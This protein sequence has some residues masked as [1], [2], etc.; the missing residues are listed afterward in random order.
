MPFSIRTTTFDD[1]PALT[2]LIAES[3]RG[4]CKSDYTEAQIEAALQ[5]A[6]GVDSELIRDQT[7]F[8]VEQNNQIIACGGWSRRK[9]LFGGDQ[10]PDRQSELLNPAKEPARIRAFFVHPKAARNG[11]GSALLK[12]CE[13][14]AEAAGFRSFELVA[15][16]PGQRL[17]TA[18]GYASGE[19]K[20]YPLPGGITIEFVPMRKE[21]RS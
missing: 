18:H 12:K 7:Y 17:Y 15:T 20:D 6:W 19:A 5:S 3:A 2:V 21:L 13:S 10:Q 14:A 11:I 9:T 4:L 1:I 8:V 16:L